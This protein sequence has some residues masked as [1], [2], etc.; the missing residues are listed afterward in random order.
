MKGTIRELNQ[1]GEPMERTVS[2]V[3]WRPGSRHT[4]PDPT[5]RSNYENLL[6]SHLLAIFHSIWFANGSRMV[7]A[8][9][10]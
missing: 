1:Y 3:Q 9:T 4:L 10:D 8:L 6:S 7:R 2:V 5:T